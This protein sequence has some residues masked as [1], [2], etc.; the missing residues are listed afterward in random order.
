MLGEVYSK[1]ACDGGKTKGTSHSSSLGHMYSRAPLLRF[2]PCSK[3]MFPPR[4]HCTLSCSRFHFLNLL[5]FLFLSFF[6][7]SSSFFPLFFVYLYP[8]FS[9]LISLV[10]SLVRPNVS[11]LHLLASAP[12]RLPP[13]S[14]PSLTSS[15]CL[16]LSLLYSPPP[17]HTPLCLPVGYLRA[18]NPVIT[19]AEA[20][21]RL[22][23]GSYQL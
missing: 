19:D 15:S 5:P 6:T 10:F 9:H 4:V 12:S 1:G 16:L 3:Y 7:F 13:L 23:D 17:P 2:I 8:R 20:R 14:C 22:R 11:R 21:W 18:K